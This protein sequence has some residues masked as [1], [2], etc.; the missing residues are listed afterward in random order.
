M[1]NPTSFLSAMYTYAR[2]I[3]VF[4]S[5][6]ISGSIVPR[7]GCVYVDMC[8]DLFHYGHV[9]LLKSASDIAVRKNLNLVVGIHSDDVIE[10]Y[11]RS[12]IMT[13][14][15]RIEVVSS[16]RYV[17]TVIPDAPLHITSAFMERNCVELVIHAHSKDDD[18]RYRQMYAGDVALGKFLRLEYTDTISTT[19]IIKRCLHGNL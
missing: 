6:S 18:E 11:K 4:L 2:N 14:N 15:E 16:C 12:P 9:R 7:R 13:M 19:D 3:I 10:S 17:Y 1:W 8:A 5:S